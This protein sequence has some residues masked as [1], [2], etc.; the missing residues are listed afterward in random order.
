VLGWI[1][2]GRLIL[3]WPAMIAPLLL[4]PYVW[5][6]RY[7]GTK[8]MLWQLRE[9]ESTRFAWH[10]VPGNLEGAWNFF[11][12]VS[13]VQPNSLWLVIVG[14]S[15]LAWALVRLWKWWRTAVTPRPPLAAGIPAIALFAATIVANLIML[16]FY[17]WSRLDEPI[18]T[19][20]ALPFCFVLSLTAGW[21]VHWLDVRSIRATRIATFGLGAWVLIV[22]APAYAHRFYTTQ[23]L[24]MH[25]IN[26]ELEQ[27]VAQRRPM[28]WITGKAT[29]PFLLEKIPAVNI[30]VAALRA[31]QISW[32]LREGT[33]HDVFVAQVLRP[34]SIKGEMI[35]DPGDVLPPEFQLRTIAEKRFGG[36]WIR[37]SALVEIT[38]TSA[39][40]TVSP[41]NVSSLALSR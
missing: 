38:P 15:G 32:H 18:A 22:A 16:M 1:R 17:Y 29:M 19:R 23:N 36:R 35:V 11:A 10:Y 27:A 39:N 5:H 24:V 12:S 28:L 26:W 40:R 33:F 9:G 31:P 14:V 37:I 8:P 7:V 34:T 30:N 21:L 13:P 4:V 2:A 3:P 20:F 41:T 25:E 6:D